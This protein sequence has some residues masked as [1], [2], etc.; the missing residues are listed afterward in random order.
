[1]LAAAIKYGAKVIFTTDN[2]RSER[3]EDIF[4]DASIGNDIKSVEV[5]E[6]RRE[7]IIQGLQL[8]GNNDCLVILGK[9]HED[10]QEINGEIIYLSDY[11]VVNEI[12]KWLK[13]FI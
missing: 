6:D 10:T 4:N 5:I 8:I 12:Y 2:S 13:W 3:F 11:E 1:M 9:G 7:A